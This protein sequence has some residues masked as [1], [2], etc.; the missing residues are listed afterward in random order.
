M[1]KEK[2]KWSCLSSA[3]KQRSRARTSVLKSWKPQSAFGQMPSLLTGFSDVCIVWAWEKLGPSCLKN[4]LAVQD[5]AHKGCVSHVKVHG[6]GK[7]ALY[8][9]EECNKA[10][11]PTLPEVF[12]QQLHLQDPF[13]ILILFDL[14]SSFDASDQSPCLSSQDFQTVCALLPW[15]Q[16]VSPEFVGSSSS[17]ILL[18]LLPLAKF[19]CLC[20]SLSPCS[21]A[22]LS[23]GVLTSDV[24]RQMTCNPLSTLPR[25]TWFLRMLVQVKGDLGIIWHLGF[26]FDSFISTSNIAQQN[27]ISFT[28]PGTTCWSCSST[29]ICTHVSPDP[30]SICRSPRQELYSSSALL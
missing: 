2:T 24:D 27:L 25:A 7:G 6:F 9:V 12:L 13:F 28:F 8:S 22:A 3:F 16:S 17:S 23:L 21:L 14:S 20:P 18:L 1:E 5:F 11:L 26:C 4:Y 10:F 19:P 30:F 29:S 15:P